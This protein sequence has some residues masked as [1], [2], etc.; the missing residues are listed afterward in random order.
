ML[1]LAGA[2]PVVQAE[3]R[4]KRREHARADVD[5][6]VGPENRRRILAL[7]DARHRL[8]LALPAAAVLPRTELAVAADGGVHDVGVARLDLAIADAEAVGGAG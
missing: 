3:A 2:Q 7:H 8:A 1:A 5:Q 4:G 6:V